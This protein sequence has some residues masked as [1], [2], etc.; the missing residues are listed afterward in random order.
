MS[1][2]TSSNNGAA[3]CGYLIVLALIGWAVVA[4]LPYIIMG[5]AA[6]LL[7]WLLVRYHREAWMVLQWAGDILAWTTVGAF[8]VAKWIAWHASDWIARR[9]QHPPAAM[10]PPLA[11]PPLQ[12]PSPVA[13]AIQVRTHPGWKLK[14]RG[15]PP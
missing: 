4:L 12:K 15:D 5:A 6:C 9:C 2:N 3:G 1:R 8:T 13:K 10:A 11:L 7:A 14:N